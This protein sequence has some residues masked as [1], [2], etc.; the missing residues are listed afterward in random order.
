[1]HHK[2]IPAKSRVVITHL[3]I[4]KKKAKLLKDLSKEAV[5]NRQKDPSLSEI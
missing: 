3:A 4:T 5:K 1:M 2:L